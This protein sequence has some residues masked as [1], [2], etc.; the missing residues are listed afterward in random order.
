ML[1]PRKTGSLEA[2]EY[3]VADENGAIRMATLDPLFPDEIGSA[4]PSGLDPSTWGV[5]RAF[6]VVHAPAEIIVEVDHAC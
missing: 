2:P 1:F 4:V 6:Y 3:Q 5:P